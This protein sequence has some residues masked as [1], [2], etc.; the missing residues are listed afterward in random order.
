MLSAECFTRHAMSKQKV[1]M[2]IVDPSFQTK[3]RDTL[4]REATVKIDSFLKR[5]TL[6]GNNLPPVA[7]CCW[8]HHCPSRVFL[9][10]WFQIT[11]ENSTLFCDYSQLL[12]SQR[13]FR[14][15]VY[16]EVKS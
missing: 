14:I 8:A 6:K 1:V 15:I 13:L 9:L 2:H 12:L 5:V 4:S 10:L 11:I 3:G 7:V 16:L